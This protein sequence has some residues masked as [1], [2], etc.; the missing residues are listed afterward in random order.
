MAVYISEL[1]INFLCGVF[2]ARLLQC[3]SEKILFRTCDIQEVATAG[4][5]SPT[6][7]CQNLKLRGL[8]PEFEELKNARGP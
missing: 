6:Q 7:K 8:E 1:V 5:R 4:L 3:L 2:G